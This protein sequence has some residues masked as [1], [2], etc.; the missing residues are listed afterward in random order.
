ML[1]FKSK[2]QNF[3]SCLKTFSTISL[4]F[5]DIIFFLKNTLKYTIRN[6][7]SNYSYRQRQILL[8]LGQ[9]ISNRTV[10]HCVSCVDEDK[11]FINVFQVIFYDFPIYIVHVSCIISRYFNI[12]SCFVSILLWKVI[13]YVLSL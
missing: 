5:L 4:A 2:W 10:L 1:E 6:N 12:V 9:R 13:S 8:V 11:C 3:I 7:I